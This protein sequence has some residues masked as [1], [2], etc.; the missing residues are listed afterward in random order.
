[1]KEP[2]NMDGT[3]DEG[4]QKGGRRAA[5]LSLSFF[6][7]LRRLQGQLPGGHQDE[8]LDLIAGRVHPLQDGDRERGRLARPVL[9]AREDVPPRQ[10]DGD[11]FLLDGGRLVEAVLVD[12]HEELPLEEVVLEF[13]A[14]GA[15]DVLGGGEVS[16]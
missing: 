7:H 12:A 9:G 13:I 3:D 5:T 4:G 8:G 1:V 14:L 6:P 11:G 2:T 16:G 10:R 15:G